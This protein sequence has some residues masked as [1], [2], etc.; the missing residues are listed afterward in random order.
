M[1]VV[2][3]V[4]IVVL[5]NKDKIYNSIIIMRDRDVLCNFDIIIKDKDMN[6]YLMDFETMNVREIATVDYCRINS[7][8]LICVKQNENESI[9]RVFNEKGGITTFLIPKLVWGNPVFVSD[10][11]YFI[12]TETKEQRYVNA[13]LYAYSEGNINKISDVQIDSISDIISY[14]NY[15]YFVEKDISNKY[16]V[17]RYNISDLSLT[18]LFEGR[19]PCWKEY[20]KTLFVSK[21]RN[22]I[23]VDLKSFDCESV[24]ENVNLVC[25]PQYDNKNNIL[26]FNW[27]NDKAS[28]AGFIEEVSLL[29]L[30]NMKKT[31]IGRLRV[32][33]QNNNKKVNLKSLL[34]YSSYECIAT[35]GNY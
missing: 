6:L 17:T 25:T 23:V 12:A 1:L 13:Y 33:I 21:N 16:Y 15:L 10:T 4:V 22:L 9:I 11:L 2:L 32:N 28:G 18:R 5:S 24:I 30:D 19:F 7:K 8:D 26:V 34:V 35:Q 29:N 20:G 3:I 27:N 14:G 31:N